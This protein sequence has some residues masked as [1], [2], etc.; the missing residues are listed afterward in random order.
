MVWIQDI[1]VKEVNKK[2]KSA[3]SSTHGILLLLYIERY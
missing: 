1:A 3:G 2:P